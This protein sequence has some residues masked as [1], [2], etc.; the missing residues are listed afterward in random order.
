MTKSDGGHFK[1][2]ECGVSLW[3]KLRKALA[4]I[5]LMILDAAR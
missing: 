1:I 2:Q 5:D 4:I 3:H